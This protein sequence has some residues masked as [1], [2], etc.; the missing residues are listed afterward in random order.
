M[1]VVV[2]LAMTLLVG[3]IFYVYNVGDQVNLRLEM[4]NAADAV[5]VSGGGFMARCMNVVAMN[6]CA[7]SRMLG[8]VP[9]FDALPLAAQMA[10]EETRD[11]EVALSAQLA[12]GVSNQHGEGPLL[13]DGL[14]TLQSRM[15]EERDILKAV[16]DTVGLGSSFDMEGQTHWTVRGAG[17]TPPHGGFWQAAET[18]DEYS[19]A[20]VKA[21]GV[22]AQANGIRFGRDNRADARFLVPLRP[23][24]PAERG[25]FV[26][27]QPVLQGEV[28]VDGA[29]VSHRDTR[30]NGG[31]IPDF[32]EPHRMGPF[33]RL[34][35][36][37]DYT[38]E[39]TGRKWVPPRAGPRV[40][41]G[42]GGGGPG[43]RS[44]GSSARQSGSGH[45]GHWAATGSIKTGYR[46]YGPYVWAMRR[47]GNWAEGRL[48]DTFFSS[49]LGRISGIKL[50]YMFGPKELKTVHYPQWITDYPEARR[51]AQQADVRVTHTLFYMV[52][53]A[54]VVPEGAPGWLSPGTF[55]TNGNKPIA[56]W[57]GG[58]WD[59]E[60]SSMTKV[61][62]YIWKTTYTYE[63][64]EDAELGLE[65]GLDEEGN[66]IWHQVYVVSWYTFGGIDIG[67]DVEVSNP[68]NWDDDDRLPAPILL[69]TAEGDYDPDEKDPD[70]GI[71]RER[72][73]Y[74]GV[75][76]EGN[77]APVWPQ[78]FS[79]ANPAKSMFT[80]AQA[81]VFNNNSWDLWTQDWQ[82]QLTPVSQTG[83]WIRQMEEGV[84][85]LGE[86]EGLVRVEEV[87]R[88]TEYFSALPEEMAELYLN[89]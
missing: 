77:T 7:Q 16:H 15:V 18:M 12:R 86:T 25:E 13:R 59:P 33:A 76:R 78:R 52:E 45:D 22:L 54:S 67:G 73:S 31:G 69:N 35:K 80:L 10:W 14:A 84:G 32:A 64:T 62:D 41:G 44:R 65:P 19:Q 8:V 72:F 58:W 88:A 71:R 6:N 30:G 20:T 70:A 81:K 51:Q 26:D 40:R 34:Y 55:R 29:V 53:V 49:Y 50:G 27:F 11:W 47:V 74:L 38:Y 82:V 79:A 60:R 36:W 28:R 24:I 56:V 57:T 66:P 4:Q 39:A 21:A 75:V 17:G 48:P 3:L 68:C 5:A 42:S 9:V 43:G 87:T 37:R 23:E 1:L 83:D 46:T 85:D 63:T 89:H 2:L 61:H